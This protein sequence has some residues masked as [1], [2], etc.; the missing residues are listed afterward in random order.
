MPTPAWRLSPG[1]TPEW[2]SVQPLSRRLVP[3]PEPCIEMSPTISSQKLSTSHTNS[4]SFTTRE[5]TFHVPRASFCS[6]GS[7]R[8]GLRLWLPP[9]THCTR[10]L[11][12][13][14]RVV[15]PSEG[16]PTFPLRAVPS[17]APWVKAWPPGTRQHAPPPGLAPEWGPGD[18][19]LGEGTLC[20]VLAII[21][22]IIKIIINY[23]SHRLVAL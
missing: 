15:S 7:D 3:E 21:K 5:V 17:R 9:I 2:K 8:Q 14:P 10:P 4:G 19:Y 16:G 12:P 1:A 11:W 13:L 20:P 23:F 22:S 6:Q 18:P